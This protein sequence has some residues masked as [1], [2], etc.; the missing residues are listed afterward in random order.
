M[1]VLITGIGGQDGYY[2]SE[3][4]LGQGHTVH[5]ILRTAHSHPLLAALGER[6]GGERLRLVYGDVTDSAFLRQVI[7]SVVPE[8]IYNLAGQSRVGESFRIPETTFSVNT[9]VPLALLE[10]VRTY[11]PQIRV[12][13][14][15]SAEVFGE[16]AAVPQTEQTPF[17]PASPYAVSKAS[18]YWLV[19]TYRR[20][21]GLYACNAILY[22]HE[23]PLRDESF[24]SGKVARAVARIVRGRQR[25]LSLGNLEV[26][27]DWG[28]AGDYVEAMWL[29]MNQPEPDDYVIAS[30]ETH[31]VGE[32]V[33]LAFRHADLDWRD[34]VEVDEG[35]YR[36]ID[37]GDMQ[38]DARL[39]RERLRWH[40]RCDFP[41]LVRM[42]VDS[43]LEQEIKSESLSPAALHIEK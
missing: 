17:A 8:Q 31:S 41:S 37:A 15:C 1:D 6:F 20:A 27:R 23:S 29:M 7:C 18:A 16:R 25:T 13:Q 9:L 22:N 2:L 38:G 4:L 12:F 21:Y 40:P 34:H 14:A 10:I 42:M 3:L 33:E 19:H 26:R 43:A 5:G 36:P 24:L 32:F 39:A 11:N 30:G 28:F 35:L